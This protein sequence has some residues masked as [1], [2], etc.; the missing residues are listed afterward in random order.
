VGERR[1]QWCCLG[2]E[3]IAE[4]LRE[5]RERHRSVQRPASLLFQT[6]TSCPSGLQRINLSAGVNSR[7]RRGDVGGGRV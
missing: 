7:A 4:E 6:Q 2:R 3:A 1:G 5:M